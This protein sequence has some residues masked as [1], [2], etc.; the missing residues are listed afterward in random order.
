MSRI[1]IKIILAALLLQFVASCVSPKEV[2]YFQNLPEELAQLDSVQNNFKIKPNDI[3]SITVT[4]YDPSAVKPFNLVLESKGGVLAQNQGYLTDV[5]GFINFPVLGRV[6][7]AGLT[8][9]ELSEKLTEEISEYILDPIVTINI[10]NFKVS[11]LGAVNSPG[12]YSVQGERFTLTEAIGLAGDLSM[13]GKRDNILVLRE[14]N[15]KKEY[16]YLDLRDAKIMESEY[17][18]L[19]QNDLIY[20]E[21][22]N[23][24]VQT[25]GIVSDPRTIL[26]II[27]LL[28]TL[29]VVFIK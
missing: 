5:D 10:L 2:V 8:R 1:A 13:Y 23:K 17:Y 19:Q 11:I 14:S 3:L 7:A 28:T 6:K 4:A 29:V 16:A 20:V 15:G 27:S 26:S 9:A 25:A 22:N 18:H 21:P 12:V 24:V